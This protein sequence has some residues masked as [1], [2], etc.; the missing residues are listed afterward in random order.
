MYKNGALMIYG[1][2]TGANNSGGINV[3]ETFSSGDFIQFDNDVGTLENYQNLTLAIRE[4]QSNKKI[5]NQV[6]QN[7]TLLE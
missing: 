2:R 3:I 1:T 6:V 7:A 5:I 4:I